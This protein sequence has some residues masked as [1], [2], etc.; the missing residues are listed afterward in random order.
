MYKYE[1]YRAQVFLEENQR[2]FLK[3]RDQVHT[4]LESCKYI[5]MDQAIAGVGGNNWLRMAYVDRLVEMREI[6]ELK[7]TPGSLRLFYK[8]ANR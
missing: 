1:D 3:I 6:F 4:L 2:D 5:D 7:C 8:N